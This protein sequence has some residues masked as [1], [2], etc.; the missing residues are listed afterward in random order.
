MVFKSEHEKSRESVRRLLG[1]RVPLTLRRKPPPNILIDRHIP[2]P[3]EIFAICYVA[4]GCVVVGRPFED[5]WELTVRD[6]IA[7]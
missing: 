4:G 3:R 7:C 5:Y 6:L 2:T 1:E